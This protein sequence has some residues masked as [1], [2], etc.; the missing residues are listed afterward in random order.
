MSKS[1]HVSTLKSHLGYWMRAVSNQV[2][3]A[4]ALKLEGKDVTVAEWVL[5]RELFEVDGMV[6][7]DLA[8][9][10][11]LTRGAVSKL[12]DRLEAKGLL[13]RTTAKKDRR[14]QSVGLTKKGRGLVPDLAA[15]ADEND[16]AFFWALKAP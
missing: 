16:E 15:L 10:V 7:S 14:F 9:A 6:P 4:F 1:A 12:V 3:H 8:T 11:G 13:A 5:M 2:S